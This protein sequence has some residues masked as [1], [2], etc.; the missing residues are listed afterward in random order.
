M[1][2]S[3]T[4]HV[5]PEEVP[6]DRDEGVVELRHAETVLAI[7]VVGLP[8]GPVEPL[9]GLV[10]GG[11][12]PLTRG[13]LIVTLLQVTKS[14]NLADSFSFLGK[15]LPFRGPFKISPPSWS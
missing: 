2:G 12:E 14:K 3:L 13:V 4:A 10:S 11:P 5:V 6:E 1:V 9:H 8:L 7:Q 15:M